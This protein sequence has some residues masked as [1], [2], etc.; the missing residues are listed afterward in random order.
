MNEQQATGNVIPKNPAIE[1]TIAP[2]GNASP[3]HHFS[4][5]L[6][7]LG[8]AATNER[9]ELSTIIQYTGRRSIGVMLLILALPMVIPIPAAG[10]SVLFGIPLI[11]VSAQLSLARR[12]MWLPGRLARLSMKRNDLLAII[13]ATLPILRRLEWL[14]RPRLL[15]MTGEWLVVPVGLICTAL[16]VIIILPI[17]LGHMLPGLAICI[18]AFGLLERDGLVLS[19]GMVASAVAFA[20]AG[21]A[22]HGLVSWI[23]G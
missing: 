14:V 16:S 23:A 20:V 1:G 10:I 7:I 12:Q 19:L 17:P 2:D 4:D 15:W 13:E 6:R 18:F 9:V 8:K 3:R 22:T 21:L 11:L 5:A